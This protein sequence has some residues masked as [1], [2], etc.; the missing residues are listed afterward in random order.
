MASRVRFS[1]FA[2]FFIVLAMVVAAHEGH[3]HSNLAPAEPPSSYASSLSYPAVIG[4]FVSF[5]VTFLF[6]RNSF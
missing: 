1:L 6:A 3:D 5:L 4:G 2:L